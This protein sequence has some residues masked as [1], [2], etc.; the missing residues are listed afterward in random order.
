MA[1]SGF[2]RAWM[3][4]D[5][6]GWTCTGF[7]GSGRFSLGVDGF[8]VSYFIW[9]GGVS[10]GADGVQCVWIRIP[11]TLHNT[12]LHHT[13]RIVDLRSYRASGS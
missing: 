9:C 12:P 4:L 3:R 5:L 10:V 6:S 13:P 1:L 8:Y 7:R 11:R 2:Q